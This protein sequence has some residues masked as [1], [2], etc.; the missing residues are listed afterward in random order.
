MKI[1]AVVALGLMFMGPGSD[2]TRQVRVDGTPFQS[3]S[4]PRYYVDYANFRNADKQTYVEFYLHVAYEDL[5]FTKDGQGFQAG[6]NFSLEIW[7]ED[8]KLLQQH[9][10]G[11]II[12]V[13]SYDET[14]H[15]ELARASLV[16][17]TLPPGRYILRTELRDMET[18]KSAR[19]QEYVTVRDF[20]SAR[21]QISDIQF[22]Q[23]ITPAPDGQPYVKNGRFVQ[24]N[25]M[26][27][28]AYGISEI[29]LYFEVYN[30][31]P[32]P[33]DEPG[34]YVTHFIF[35]NENGE[36]VAHIRRPHRKPGR[37]TAQSIKLPV[38]PF[39][40]GRYSVTVKI[41]DS[42]NLEMSE[43]SGT[44]SVLDNAVSMTDADTGELYK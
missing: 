22:S 42:D 10:T 20:K 30:L 40:S 9:Q 13:D 38:E 36:Q 26:K 44:F 28:F 6:Y 37:M 11:D 4:E 33:G 19:I 15:S 25:A 16:A 29:N 1:F 27:T 31:R 34:N 18:K 12:Q 24:P 5:H 8:E 43:V 23:Q 3:N 41:E 14:I 17:Y 21:L 7:S 35:R 2:G 39:L 32:T